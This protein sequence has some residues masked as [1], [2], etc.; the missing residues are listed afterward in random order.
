MKS[1]TIRGIRLQRTL[2][3]SSQHVLPGFFISLPLFGLLAR[4]QR[5]FQAV[6]SL[7]WA[8]RHAHY[9]ALFHLETSQMALTAQFL[10]QK[11]LFC[12]LSK[13]QLAHGDPSQP[14]RFNLPVVAYTEPY[15]AANTLLS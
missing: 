7:I 15:R 5:V 10:V 8:F 14:M 11:S 2:M 6:D 3:P 12:L 1:P 13:R 9:V 4:V